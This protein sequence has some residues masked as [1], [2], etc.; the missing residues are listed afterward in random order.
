MELFIR[1]KNGQPFEH[2]IFGDNFCQ[3]F[4]DIDTENLP[5]SF[6]R[7]VRVEPPLVGMYEVYE[8][9]TYGWKDDVVTDFHN[10]RA[11]T[12]EEIIARQDIVKANWADS[13][14]LSWVFNEITCSFEPPVAYPTDGKSY[15]WDELSTSW[16]EIAE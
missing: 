11:M 13:G 5:D 10:I 14:Y 6:A 15:K 4:P 1:L 7:F 3:A 2:P 9:V 8:G 16:V 12:P